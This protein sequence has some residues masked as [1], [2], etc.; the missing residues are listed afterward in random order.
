MN[1]QKN[2]VS[3]HRINKNIIMFEV[4]TRKKEA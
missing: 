3:L 1:K 2:K 4:R